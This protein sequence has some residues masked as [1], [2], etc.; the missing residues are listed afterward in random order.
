MGGGT[1][2][3]STDPSDIAATAEA[4][5][6]L[7]ALAMAFGRIDRTC[8]YHATGEKESDTD[9]TVM[10]S[11]VAPSL[12]AKLYPGQLDVGLVAQ[13]ASVHD[14]VE[15]HAGDTPTLRIDAAGKAAKAER[16][17]AAAARI[18][19]QFGG[20]LPWLA[21]MVER[22]EHQEEPEARFVRAVDKDMPKLV[23]V[24]DGARGLAEEGI[25]AAELAGIYQRQ[26]DDIS[27][28]A[29]EWTE[30][31]QLHRELSGRVVDMVAEQEGGT[32]SDQDS[33]E[34]RAQLEAGEAESARRLAAAAGGELEIWDVT[35]E[36][37]PVPFHEW[38]QQMYPHETPAGALM[39]FDRDLM[40]SDGMSRQGAESE[41]LQHARQR[42]LSEVQ[43]DLEA[44]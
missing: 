5:T 41:A 43:A 12:A 34:A 27:Q 25:G 17:R 31:A 7:G 4:V 22:Y 6:E 37:E 29:G 44:G 35:A 13:F 42:A 3:G 16:E 36:P 15:V 9:H 11:W 39:A 2:S 23:H 20:R 40:V 33:S 38:V 19:E 8:C 24:E 10:L 1:L 30:L 28:Y 26:A 18:T 21:E 32:V 14:A